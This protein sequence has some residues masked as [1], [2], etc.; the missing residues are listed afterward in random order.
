MLS[1]ARSQMKGLT[2]MNRKK[3]SKGEAVGR[4]QF[5]PLPKNPGNHS[6][7]LNFQEISLAAIFP[8][9]LVS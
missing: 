1:V 4:G 2:L 7:T 8:E 9:N 5:L 3:R 6:I